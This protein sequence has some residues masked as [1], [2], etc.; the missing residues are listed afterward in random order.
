MN[1]HPYAHVDM[2]GFSWKLAA[3]ERKLGHELDL[4]TAALATAQREAAGLR[5]AAQRLERE[6]QEQLQAAGAALARELDPVAHRRA[7][8]YLVQLRQRLWDA[9]RAAEAGHS[10]VREA[11]Q[12]C[13]EADRK[14]ASVRRVRELS[15]RAYAQAQG[16][17][18]AREADRSWLARF[19][20]LG[21]TASEGTP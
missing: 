5:E 21:R 10:R 7:L 16:R 4:A 14:L 17:R 9:L 3:L 19:G 12:A 13:I 6:S 1:M 20:A 2:R 8:G 18:E 11:A 15:E